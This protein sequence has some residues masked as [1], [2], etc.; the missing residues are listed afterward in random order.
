M[1]TKEAPIK[2]NFWFN[3]AFSSP[4]YIAATTLDD[5]QQEI[6]SLN[7]EISDLEDQKKDAKNAMSSAQ[8]GLNTTNTQINSISG[9]MGDLGE[10]I[11]GFESEN[12]VE[13]RKN[14]LKSL[15]YGNRWYCSAFP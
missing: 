9:A 3:L 4:V 6:D 14:L 11:E 15:E 2:S 8:S 13:I 1:V 10:E 7:S 12:W 5:I